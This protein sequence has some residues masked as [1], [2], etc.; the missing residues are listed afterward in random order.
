MDTQTLF[1]VNALFFGLYAGV[2]LV[3]ARIIGSTRGVVWFAGA[4]VSRAAAMTLMGLAGWGLL[5]RR[6]TELV[7]GL[8]VVL[9]ITMLHR[10][11]TE[12]LERSPLLRPVQY[13][14][15]ILM[16]VATGYFLWRPATAPV[17]MFLL[18]MV[19]GIQSALIAAV[20]LRFSGDDAGPAGWL[21]GIALTLYC[22][23]M[24]MRALVT[25]RYNSP[26]YPAVAREMQRVWLVSCMLSNAAVTFGYMFLSAARLRMELQWRAQVDELT[27]LLNRW[28][29]KRVATREII[30]CRRSGSALALIMMD[31]DGLKGINDSGGHGCG[32]A[33][34][35]AVACVLQETVRGQ[36]SVARMGGDEFCILLPETRVTEAM[37]VAERLRSE[38]DQ[39][40]VRYR[41]EAV[42]IKASLGVASSEH[43]ELTWQTLMDES[44]AA[45]YRA[46]R[47]GKNRVVLAE[48]KEHGGE[49]VGL[50]KPR[51]D[52]EFGK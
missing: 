10:S 32:D 22:G 8:L 35:Q 27:G 11:F 36:D 44:D 2:V 29:M 28:A 18:F 49:R 5:S 23:V 25:L 7:S 19:V 13:G 14:L 17:S 3:N 48:T 39:L 33:V 16:T 37:M 9:G 20:V 4:S 52:V 47:D 31:L 24:L 46:K 51:T 38:V 12:L 41:S 40:A 21:T 43:C 34:L 50:V 26:G 42:P 15:L 30:R 6:P 45:L 1:I